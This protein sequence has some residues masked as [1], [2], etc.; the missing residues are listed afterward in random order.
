MRVKGQYFRTIWQKEDDKEII[1]II[2]QRLLPHEFLVIDLLTFHDVIEAIQ[3]MA[4]RGAPLIGGTAAWGVYLAAVQAKKNGLGIPFI[5]DACKELVLARPTATNLK[6]SIDRILKAI[7]S[8]DNLEE[9]L[10]K[11]EIGSHRYLQ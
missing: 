10:N 9:I 6:W 2:D 4:V 8:L 5:L 7:E 11:V 3:D 1:Q